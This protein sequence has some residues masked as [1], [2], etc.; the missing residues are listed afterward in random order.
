MLLTSLRGTG[1]AFLRFPRRQT[2]TVNLIFE[3]NPQ[4]DCRC[5]SFLGTAIRCSLLEK[6]TA[7]I[8]AMNLRVTRR[9]LFRDV[10]GIAIVSVV[11]A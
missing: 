11:A 5:A 4:R 2:L 9:T 3:S 6:H 1:P 7:E 10:A 8:G